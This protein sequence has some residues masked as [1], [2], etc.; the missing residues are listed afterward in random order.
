MPSSKRLLITITMRQKFNEKTQ[1]PVLCDF[2]PLITYLLPQTE[3]GSAHSF[4]FWKPHKYNKPIAHLGMWVVH[5]WV[6]ARHDPSIRFAM[7]MYAS[8]ACDRFPATWPKHSQYLH[9]LPNQPA[10]WHVSQLEFVTSFLTPSTA[11]PLACPNY[12]SSSKNAFLERTGP[13]KMWL[14]QKRYRS[15][16]LM[17]S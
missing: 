10:W 3:V 13:K 16:N 17:T 5:S 11:S 1:E 6:K 2:L 15:R 9:N 4:S 7:H 14:L 12:L 8:W